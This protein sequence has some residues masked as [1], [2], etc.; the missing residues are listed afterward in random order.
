MITAEACKAYGMNLRG[1]KVAIQGFGNV[2]SWTAKLIAELGAKVVAV[3]DVF[4]GIF[5]PE[6]LDIEKVFEHI[7]KTGSVV[8]MHGTQSIDNEQLL[9]L[10]VDVLI[11][12]ALGGSIDRDNADNVKAK[13]IVEAANSPVT[14]RAEEKLNQRGIHIIPDILANAG[15]VTVS[16]FEWVQNLQQFHWS[17]E[18]VNEELQLRMLQAWKRVYERS[19]S[20]HAKLPLRTAAYCEALDKVAQATRH[21]F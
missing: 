4:G 7:K 21:R 11:P 5:R 20:G 8:A 17:L 9:A 13:L 19:T 6:G 2:G 10:D 12:A 1:A 14:P 3:S 16:Y 18:K 15:G